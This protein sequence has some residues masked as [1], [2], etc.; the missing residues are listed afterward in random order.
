MTSQVVIE[1]W[2]RVVIG[3]KNDVTGCD[4]SKYRVSMVNFSSAVVI[5]FSRWSDIEWW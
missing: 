2:S 1:K 4:M 5:F 3:S